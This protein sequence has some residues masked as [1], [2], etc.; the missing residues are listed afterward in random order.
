MTDQEIADAFQAVYNGFWLKWRHR[1]VVTEEQW[2]I[3][4]QEARSLV[5]R[6]PGTIVTGMVTEL[7]LEMEKRG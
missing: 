5:E 6:Y 4:I 1:K 2:E 7:L 3:L